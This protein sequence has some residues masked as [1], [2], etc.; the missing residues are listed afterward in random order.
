MKK[1][2]NK[3]VL[4]S[5]G[6]ILFVVLFKPFSNEL[7]P[8]LADTLETIQTPIPNTIPT[9]ELNESE[10][11]DI[12][13]NEVVVVDVKGQVLTPGVYT[14]THGSRVL[15]AIQLAGGILPSADEKALNLAA[16]L[17]DE[18]VIYVPLIGEKDVATTIS[19]TPDSTRE[20]STIININTA[21]EMTLMTLS[22]IGPSKAKAI[23]AYREE[24]GLFQSIEDLKEVSGI[25]DQTFEQLK[26]FISVK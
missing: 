7:A 5:A 9:E 3:A 15:D 14:L 13:I 6:I 17:T 22:G 11:P 10:E 25:G 18:M 23:L 24:K 12:E 1:H 8:P 16:K 2:T 21:D 26:D 19:T 4:V 20:K